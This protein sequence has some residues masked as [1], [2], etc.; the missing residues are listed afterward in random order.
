MLRPCIGCGVLIESGSRCPTCASPPRKLRGR[1][2][3]RRR[4]EVFAAKG[5]T[6]VYC[7]N[8]ATEVDHVLSVKIGGADTI[9]NLVPSCQKC[10]RRK[11]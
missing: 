8:P 1:P 2:W 7:G 10:N 3:R 11:G 4:E 5:R 9:E 6:C